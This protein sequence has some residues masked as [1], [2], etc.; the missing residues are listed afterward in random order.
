MHE[1]DRLRC[2][3]QAA[4]LHGFLALGTLGVC[5]SAIAWMVWLLADNRTTHASWLL[6]A[7]ATLGF[8]ERYFTARLRLDRRLLEQLAAGHIPSLQALDRYLVDLGLIPNTMKTRPLTDRLRGI[9]RLMWLH[10]LVVLL[11]SGL[12]GGALLALP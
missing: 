4:L 7:C 12:L 5:L 6:A 3:V 8:V 2:T 9:R 10:G 1:A 11:Q